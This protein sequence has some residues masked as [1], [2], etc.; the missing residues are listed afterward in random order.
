[1][2]G[3]LQNY[4]FIRQDI[5]TIFN[6]EFMLANKDKIFKNAAMKCEI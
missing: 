6:H 4:H 5:L 2:Y 3:V 1:M